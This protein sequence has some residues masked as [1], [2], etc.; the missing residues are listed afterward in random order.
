M[1]AALVASTV[2]LGSLLGAPVASASAAPAEQTRSATATG[3]MDSPEAAVEE[4]LASVRAS[5][6]LGLLAVLH[7][8]ERYLVDTLYTNSTGSAQAAGTVEVA[9]L[10]RALHVDVTTEAITV[11]QVND[12][13][14]WVTTATAQVTAVL[15]VAQLDAAVTAD[16]GGWDQGDPYTG[17]LEPRTDGLGIA[18]VNDGGR[19]FVS[20]LYTSAE[21]ARRSMEVLTPSAVAEPPANG[22]TTPEAA[23]QALTAA[24]SAKDWPGVAATLTPFERRLVD[25]YSTSIGGECSRP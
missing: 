21:I 20:A 9:A 17:E 16:L 10:L 1:K 3:G 6:P 2:L 12:H 11:E 5:D 24:V 18:V 8:D 25:D 14:A 23:V 22:A 15:D 4:L 7:P 19:W 13:V